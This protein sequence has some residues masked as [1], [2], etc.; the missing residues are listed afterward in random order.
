MRLICLLLLAATPAWA[1]E[2]V[3]AESPPA[4][5]APTARVITQAPPSGGVIMAGSIDKATFA[6]TLAQGPQRFIAGLSVKPVMEGRRFRGFQLVG[7]RP[8]SPLAGSVNLRAGDVIVSV[9]GTPVER[10]DQFMKAW[11]ALGKAAHIDVALRRA[12]NKM[13]YRWTIGR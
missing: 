8:D 9:N 4:P 7:T 6:A 5:K 3:K 1:G 12:G 2:P 11:D 13:V 10:P